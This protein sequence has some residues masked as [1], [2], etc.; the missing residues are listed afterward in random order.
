MRRSLATA[1]LL[2]GCALLFACGSSEQAA[3]PGGG[4]AAGQTGSRPAP[5]ADLDPEEARQHLLSL[6]VWDSSEPQRDRD[7]DAQTCSDKVLPDTKQAGGHP[8]ATI[9][10]WIECMKEL[11]WSPKRKS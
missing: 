6:V 7:A 3:G 4:G 11:G 10:R 1:A 2:S 8:L 9:H 5:A